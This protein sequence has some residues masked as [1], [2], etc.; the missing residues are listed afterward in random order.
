MLTGD[1][2]NELALKSQS[3]KDEGEE[4]MTASLAEKIIAADF[5]A[6]EKNFIAK[7]AGT[8]RHPLASRQGCITPKP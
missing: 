1:D 6:I 4:L 3:K 5:E 8:R 2:F 7:A